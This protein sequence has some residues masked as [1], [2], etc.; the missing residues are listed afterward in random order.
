MRYSLL[1]FA[2]L[3]AGLI[4]NVGTAGAQP[5]ITS[6][7]NSSGSLWYDVTLEQDTSNDVVVDVRVGLVMVIVND[8]EY[9]L[10]LSSNL[11][12]AHVGIT[13]GDLNDVV[14]V[15]GIDIEQVVEPTFIG[16]A[17]FYLDVELE[18]GE[19]YFEN[20][21]LNKAT[22]EGGHGDDTLIGGPADEY[23]VGY[24]GDDLLIGNGGNDFLYGERGDDCLLGG[25]GDDELRGGEGLDKLDG[26][27]GDDTL[28]GATLVQTPDPRSKP[29]GHID[30]VTGG[31][32][33]DCFIYQTFRYF[34][35]QGGKYEANGMQTV[36]EDDVLDFSA[37]E[38]DQLKTIEATPARYARAPKY[39]LMSIGG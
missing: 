18:G 6:G 33:A 1:L 30:S 21:S 36:D 19:D 35:I 15:T 23:L 7:S 20:T 39:T 37:K 10:F 9:P 4:L 3:A 31:P 32:G 25:T 2:A 14:V 22:V 8:V 11:S 17:K 16:P 27:E 5:A 26:G 24:D 13:S 12:G 38:G 29:D 28:H 34:Q